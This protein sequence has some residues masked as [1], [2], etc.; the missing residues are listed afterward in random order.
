[1]T[2][3][4]PPAESAASFTAMDLELA[5]FAA[6]DA[7]D[8]DCLI[9]A[10]LAGDEQS[11][12]ALIA[13]Y[14]GLINGVAA[15]Y[16]LPEADRADI[17]QQVSIELWR[18]L[19]SIKDRQR[20]PGWLV[21]VTARAAW[22]CIRQR[23]A[24]QDHTDGDEALEMQADRGWKP[25]ELLVMAE[26]WATLAQGVES[27]EPRD[28]QLLWSLFFDPEEPSYDD[29]ARQLAVPKN[30]VGPMRQRCLLRLRQ[31]LETSVAPALGLV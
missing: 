22:Q 1:M 18:K 16:G 21:T 10:C 25:D 29:I 17:F 28:R 24:Q 15:R 7:D 19:R 30:S 12:E 27:L 2:V 14:A 31:H 20:L 6:L 23:R 4:A 13:R 9:D 8:L 5:G 26:G 3:S 11:W